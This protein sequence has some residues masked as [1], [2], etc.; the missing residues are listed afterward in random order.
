MENY[1]TSFILYK[2]KFNVPHTSG[3]WIEAYLPY[4]LKELNEISNLECL[5]NSV[6][7]SHSEL[8]PRQPY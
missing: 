1:Y 7:R 2:L 6:S 3:Y 8:F 5:R 4:Q